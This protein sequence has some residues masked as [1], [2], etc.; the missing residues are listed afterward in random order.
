MKK[1][2]I[3]ASLAI[4]ILFSLIFVG[5]KKEGKTKDGE[6]NAIKTDKGGIKNSGKSTKTPK[7]I[8]KTIDKLSNG[9]AKLDSAA[10]KLVDA[11]MA[12]PAPELIIETTM[13]NIEISLNTKL[14]P[15]SSKNF[16][17]YA[18]TGFYKNTIF[19]R[20]MKTFMIQGG[21]FKVNKQKKAGLTGKITN[22]ADNGLKN[23]RG[24]LA[25]ARTTPPHTAQAQFFINVVDNKN[26]DHRSKT[27]RGWGYAVF[28]KV[29]KGLD[30]VDKIRNAPITPQGGA[31]AN[32]P[33]NMIIIKDIRIK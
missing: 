31:F 5:C 17:S 11:A 12:K 23:V 29:T 20:V 25:M 30:V 2:T 21:G 1:N 26:L 7:K 10:Q 4:L 14:A 13:G 16:L 22:E 33:T 27:Q 3:K 28:G 8:K 24:T 6:S 15:I 32:A 18:A 19:H 9:G